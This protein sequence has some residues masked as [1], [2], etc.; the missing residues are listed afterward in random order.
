MPP[1]QKKSLRT[2]AITAKPSETGKRPVRRLREKSK[3]QKRRPVK[4]SFAPG[5][6]RGFSL[7]CFFAYFVVWG[8][9]HKIADGLFKFGFSRFD[10]AVVGQH[11]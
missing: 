8:N 1:W 10:N 3:K 4:K 2:L 7:F 6:P 5:I 9:V 11:V